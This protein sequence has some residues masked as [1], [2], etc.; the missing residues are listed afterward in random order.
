MILCLPK[1]FMRE[2]LLRFLTIAI[3]IFCLAIALPSQAK[4]PSLTSLLNKIQQKSGVEV[5]LPSYLPPESEKIYTQ[6]NANINGYDVSLGYEPNCSGSACM[7]GSFQGS[8]KDDLST[9]GI[10]ISFK[11]GTKTKTGQ[12]ADQTCPNCGDSSLSWKE[13][14]VA[15]LIRYKVPGNTPQKRQ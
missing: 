7:L 15:Y 1:K 11:T 9:E 14:H 5:Y 2:K 6:W 4:N 12:Y 3:L 10:L 13:N 8:S